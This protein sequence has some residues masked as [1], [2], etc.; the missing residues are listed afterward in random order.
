MIYAGC[1]FFSGLGSEDSKFQLSGCYCSRGQTAA[2]FPTALQMGPKKTAATG[3]RRG[4]GPSVAGPMI[5]I[6]T[7]T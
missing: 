2:M 5:E 1:P 4:L 7:A 6:I 3:T